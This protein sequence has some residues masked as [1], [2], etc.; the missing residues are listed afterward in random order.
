MLVQF[1]YL[2]KKKENLEK[3]TSS[4]IINFMTTLYNNII[5]RIIKFKLKT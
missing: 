4:N 2:E 1:Y 5:Y 3:V